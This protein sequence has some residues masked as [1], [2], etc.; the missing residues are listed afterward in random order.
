MGTD[1]AVS[2]HFGGMGTGIGIERIQGS[3]IL[4]ITIVHDPC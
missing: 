4:M 3:H 2:D 1:D